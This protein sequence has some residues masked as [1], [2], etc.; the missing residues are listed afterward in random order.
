M[1]SSCF[2]VRSAKMSLP[3]P[4]LLQQGRAAALP[5]RGKTRQT[6]SKQERQI[7]RVRQQHTSFSF[8]SIR[9]RAA[10]SP[11]SL[12][13]ELAISKAWLTAGVMGMTLAPSGS[14]HAVSFVLG[15]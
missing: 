2:L 3:V 5:S 11:G 1:F 10:Y 13:P 6:T 12:G 9:C 4:F 14:C 7:F 8:V 15:L